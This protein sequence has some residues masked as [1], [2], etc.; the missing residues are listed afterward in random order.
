MCVCV[1]VCVCVRRAAVACVG[2]FY[3]RMGRM[4][5]SSFPETINNLL[6]AMKS[7]EVP[8]YHSK[9]VILQHQFI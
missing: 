1:C 7:A 2:A 6:K 4:L 9:T 5:G 8:A 3:E